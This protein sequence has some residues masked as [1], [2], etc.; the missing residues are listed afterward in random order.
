MWATRMVRKRRQR[1]KS[2]LLLQIEPSFSCLPAC[3]QVTI[4][5]A[6]SGSLGLRVL[7]PAI[8]VRNL[9]RLL[10]AANEIWFSKEL[11]AAYGVG[12][13]KFEMRPIESFSTWGGIRFERRRQ[14]FCLYCWSCTHTKF[15]SPFKLR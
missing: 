14:T 7:L 12:F 15:G 11:N 6:L 5:T 2:L 1:E 9:N 13:S 3:S 8:Q 4:V 10:R